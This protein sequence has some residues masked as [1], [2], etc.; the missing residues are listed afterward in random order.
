MKLGFIGSGK[1]AT[2]LVHG[3]V[4]S[5]A[6]AREEIL[7]CD[8]APGLAEK[9]AAAVQAGATASSEELARQADTLVLCVKP[10]DALDALRG[11]RGTIGGKLVVSIVAG[12]PLATL[13]P[14]AI[15]QELAKIGQQ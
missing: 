5:R 1:M 6:F 13:Q 7:V 10:V 9:L 14:M 3:A 12:L 15:Q 4:S 2:A 11:L 8:A